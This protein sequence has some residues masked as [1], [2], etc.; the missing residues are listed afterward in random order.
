MTLEDVIKQNK[1]AAEKLRRIAEGYDEDIKRAEEKIKESGR[2]TNSDLEYFVLKKSDCLED[3]EEHER[4]AGWLTELK[5]RREEECPFTWGGD[6]DNKEIIH[7]I[8]EHM[9]IHSKREPLASARLNKAFLIAIEKLKADKWNFIHSKEDLPKESG[10]YLVSLDF[11][12]VSIDYYDKDWG[13]VCY[14]GNVIAW[15]PMP[16]P[17]GES[18]VENER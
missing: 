1:E 6:I 10:K 13:F 2:N 4:L 7:L 14:I 5:E 8:R 17:C 18:E 3:A 9:R 15:K 16:K 11:G 12:D